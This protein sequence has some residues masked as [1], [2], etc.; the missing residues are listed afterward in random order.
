[1]A[2]ISA[3]KG[4]LFLITEKIPRADAEKRIKKH[5]TKAFGLFSG[6]RS[7]HKNAEK[8]EVVQYQKQF[9]PF[10]LI[11]G[12]SLFEYT[13]KT[14]YTVNVKPEVRSL[15]IQNKKH[16]VHPDKPEVG[17]EA[18][19][20]CYEVY[21]KRV[22][23]HG[24]GGNDKALELFTQQPGKKIKASEL[25]KQGLV[26]E[27]T[28]KASYLLRDMVKDLIHPF[29]ADKVIKEK[30]DIKTLRLNFKPIHVFEVRKGAKTAT[31]SVDAVTGIISKAHPI[32]DQ[33]KGMVNEDTFFDV[34][35]EL[36]GLIVPGLGLGVMLS[37]KVKDVYAKKKRLKKMKSS[38]LARQKSSRRK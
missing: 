33:L 3:K 16:E 2:K 7:L 29:D 10:W 25:H 20:H 36:A 6:L 28:V 24:L 4:E 19:D 21:H 35:A 15:L 1:M 38:K 14:R 9:V 34:G 26:L 5:H 32:A 30:V 37:K 23:K 17:F 22:L 13:R 27:P 31:L 12:E 18:I 11:E 8:M